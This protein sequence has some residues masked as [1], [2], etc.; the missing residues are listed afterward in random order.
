MPAA[1]RG[2]E[3]GRRGVLPQ[4]A[5]GALLLVV[6]SHSRNE[7]AGVALGSVALHCAMN[8]PCPVMVV[9]PPTTGRRGPSGAAESGT[10]GTAG[11]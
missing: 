8:A 4:Q 1:Q 5:V 9:H 3:P 2:A 10:T 7:L 6:G 11:G